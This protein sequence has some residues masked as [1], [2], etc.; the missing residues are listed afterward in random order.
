MIM[1]RFL[2]VFGLFAAAAAAWAQPISPKSG[3]R[4]VL[5]GNGLAERMLY[6]DHFETEMHL[7][8]PEQGLVVRNMAR[9]GDTPGFRPHASRKSQWAFPGAEQFHPDKQQHLGEGFFP[10]P[11]EWLIHE[12]ADTILAFFGYNES[13]DGPAGLS[14]FSGELDAFVKHTLAQRYNGTAVPR[15]V[16]VS[17]IAFEDLSAKR[18]LPDGKAEN[19]NLALYTDAMKKV[20]EQNGIDLI[21]LFTA[22]NVPSDEPRTINGFAPSDAGYRQLAPLLADGA[23]GKQERVSKADPE[24]LRKAVI[25]KDWFW[26]NDFHIVNGVHVYGRRHEPFGPANYPDEI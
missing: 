15:L 18:D 1:T 21:D 10:T 3:E 17:P 6:F 14:N 16:L 22:T 19:T 23:F 11:D 7:R 9:P 20:A 5:I 8:Y 26:I 25:E 4:I 24:L 2:T 13:F 12:K